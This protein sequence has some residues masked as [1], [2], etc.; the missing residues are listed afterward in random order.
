[1][2]TRECDVENIA[3]FAR[4]YAASFVGWHG[5]DKGIITPT[6]VGRLDGA[7]IQLRFFSKDGDNFIPTDYEYFKFSELKE[8]IDFGRPKLGI[9]EDGPT[10]VFLSQTTPREPRKGLRIREARQIE[11]NGWETRS[12]LLRQNPYNERMDWVWH[13]F[14]PSFISFRDALAKLGSG[15]KIGVA[16]SQDIG[17]YTVPQTLYPLVAFKRWTVGY[18]RSEVL[19][20]LHPNYAD[21]EQEIRR[22]TGAE[23]KVS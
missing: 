10:V 19:I 3:D 15:E 8:H 13:S 23:V 17:L 4:Y 20:I 7:S 2:I 9:I 14:N 22:I 12:V 11:F 5:R 6:A 1:M 16:L 21:Y 18:V